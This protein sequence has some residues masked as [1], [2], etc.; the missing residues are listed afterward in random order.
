MRLTLR[1]MLAYLDG[2]LD[3]TDAEELAHRIE[4]S[5]DARRVMHRIR[6]VTRRLKL[7]APKVDGRGLA[8]DANTV[9]E[10]LDNTLQ[11]ERAPE[12]EKIC[13]E[14]DVHLA[15]VASVHQILALIL[16][17]KATF[18]PAICKRMYK[19]I[20][21]ADAIEAEASA[22][23]PLQPA[24]ADEAPHPA[25]PRRKP[26][27]PDYLRTREQRNYVPLVLAAAILVC[28]GAGSVLFVNLGGQNLFV[29]STDENTPE[30]APQENDAPIKK[31][32]NKTF[33]NGVTPSDNGASTDTPGSETDANA[34][35]PEGGATEGTEPANPSV[36]EGATGAGDQTPGMP[37]PGADEPAPR[38]DAAPIAKAASGGGVPP[39]PRPGSL[40]EGV[41][42]EFQTDIDMEPVNPGN[43]PAVP[44]PPSNPGAQPG[45]QPGPPAP[46]DGAQGD[47][48]AG[49][50]ANAGPGAKAEAPTTPKGPPARPTTVLDDDALQPGGGAGSAQPAAGAAAV[51]GR[52]TSDSEVLLR[53]TGPE[54]IWTRLSTRDGLSAG[55]E[56]IAL[57]SFR[58]SI[59]F[60]TPNGAIAQLLG[61]TVARLLPPTAGGVP[62]LHVIDGQAVLLTTGK[63]GTQ[64][65]LQVAD[66]TYLVTFV[67]PDSTL[68]VE[69][70]RVLP[71]GGDP[72]R[73]PA[74]TTA[75]L[76]VSSGVVDIGPVSGGKHEALSVP[77]RKTLMGVPA[78]EQAATNGASTL[79]AWIVGTTP[80]QNDKRATVET[81]RLLTA[82]EPV[83]DVLEDLTHE[84]RVEFRNLA[85]LSLTIMGEFNAFLPALNDPMQKA[86]W[87]GQIDAAR[88]AI[89]RNHQTAKALKATF[90][91]QRDPKPAADLYKLLCGVSRQ[92]LLAGSDRWLVNELDNDEMDYR[93]LAFWN[94]RQY[95]VG[96]LD[97][98]PE[99]NTA[100]KRAVGV[101]AWKLRSEARQI[102]PKS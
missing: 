44:M 82:G 100:K 12:F 21:E 101:R 37:E 66:K 62:G 39:M 74:R 95:S 6:D 54:H 79:P 99:H 57:P 97:Y 88:R 92:E 17:E 43:V 55:N 5:E 46:G 96:T 80:N 98:H 59:S 7:G 36:V 83:Q 89:A 18:D 24:P 16:S 102:V 63:P 64:L 78:Q 26:E 70:R 51:V 48:A 52:L 22:Q 13:L 86:Y 3:R 71:E 4:D 58:P 67:D 41:P 47:A 75:E 31:P 30:V 8:S 33:P 10:Y 73:D 11:A 53:L 27:I 84:R 93:V 65:Q 38:G 85:V 29:A 40:T 45:P 91:A 68:A 15:E 60:N 90:E 81:E 77:D 20:E 14:S 72:I 9:S 34:N 19:L 28:I 32:A 87:N 23:K 2:V 61:G 76:F 1:T 50:K 49:A 56:L 42:P 35:A 94:L 69:V 25:K